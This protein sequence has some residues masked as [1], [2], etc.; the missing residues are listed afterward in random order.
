MGN[1]SLDEVKYLN[2]EVL[3]KIRAKMQ[4]KVFDLRGQEKIAAEEDLCYL[5]DHITR[6]N[7][8]TKFHE[9]IYL[10]NFKRAPK[11]NS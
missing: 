1:F 8:S 2:M 6:L 4:K 11:Q 5:D 9:E 7:N 3:L 10:K